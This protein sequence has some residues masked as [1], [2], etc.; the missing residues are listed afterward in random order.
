M[1]RQVVRSA[2]QLWETRNN[3]VPVQL[4]LAM[5]LDAAL[6]AEVVDSLRN[7]LGIEPVVTTR[8]NPD[9]IAGFVARV[10]DKVYDASTRAML[11]RSRQAMV[12]RAVEAIQGNPDQFIDKNSSDN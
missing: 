11:E 7:T 3:R 10:G 12:M 9:L 2:G 6:H 8:I 1:L 5:D 4:E